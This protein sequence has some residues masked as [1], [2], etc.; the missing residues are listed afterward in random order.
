MT[1][2]NEIIATEYNFEEELEKARKLAEPNLLSFKSDQFANDIIGA[3]CRAINSTTFKYIGL[4]WF[5]NNYLPKCQFNWIHES[6]GTKAKFDNTTKN[7]MASR[8]VRYVISYG[9]FL[10]QKRLITNSEGLTRTVYALELN[11]DHVA[12]IKYYKEFNNM[13]EQ[14]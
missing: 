13:L 9:I 14:E 4:R 7:Y 5:K 6:V 3:L 8:A 2:T 12:V 11:T 10:R 1:E